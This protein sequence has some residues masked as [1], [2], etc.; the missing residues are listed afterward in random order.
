M[1]TTG[2]AARCRSNAPFLEVGYLDG[3]T[4][5]QILL[6]NMPTQGTQFTNDQIQYKAKFVFGGDIIDFRG[7]QK[8]V[9]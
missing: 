7:V 3:Y 6:A 5:P 1:R 4:E 2:T 8:H 9:V